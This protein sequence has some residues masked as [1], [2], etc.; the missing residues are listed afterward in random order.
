VISR[1]AEACFWL[2]RYIERADNTAR[3]LRVNRSFVLDVNLPQA[4]QWRPVV[5]VSGEQERFPSLYSDEAMDDGELV[6]EYL[7]WNER[8]PTSILNSIKWAR[9]NAR[10]IREAIS[11]EMWESLNTFHHW[12]TSRKGRRL[13]DRDRD[14]FYRRVRDAAALFL[15]LSRNTVLHDEP[16]AFMQLGVKL[17][18]AGQT[19]RIVDVKHH[20]LGPTNGNGRASAARPDTAIEAAH[21]M[22]LLRSCSAIEPFFKRASRTPGGRAVV[23]F[24]YGE[25]LFPRSVSYC[26]DHA[27]TLLRGIRQDAGLGVGAA[28]AQG[29]AALVESVHATANRGQFEPDLHAEL[30]RVIDATADVCG[31]IHSDYFDP[32]FET[33]EPE[34]SAGDADSSSQRQPGQV[35]S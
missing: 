33:V 21:A 17:E 6:Q 32:S 20:A 26:L 35:Q 22:A 25:P 30:T 31:A 12:L 4:A 11:L 10:T 7:T 15:G 24:L 2:H 14:A 16:Y 8:N 9:E 27:W 23:S 34:N 19:A 28:S 13:F 5:V 18:R 3:L 29:L 1:V